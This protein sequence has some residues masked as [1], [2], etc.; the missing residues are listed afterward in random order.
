MIKNL[1]VR[2]T[3]TALALAGTLGLSLTACN[4][5]VVDFNK[6]F[7]VAIEPNGDSISVVPITKYADYQGSQVQFVTTDGLVVLSSTHQ[8]QLMKANSENALTSYTSH[9]V[10]DNDTINYYSTDVEYGDSF[11]KTIIDLQFVFKKAII[12]KGDS[13]IIM[14]IDTW[15]DY[16]EDDKIQIRLEDGTCILTD[17]ANI[18]LLDVRNA[19]E[20]A[21]LNYA[22]SL[23]GDKEKVKELKK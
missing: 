15:K 4:K 6:S 11:N 17:A 14:D 16:E 21:A 3:C 12:L 5:Q 23:V 19:P 18:K 10:D 9:L 13:A 7:N 2:K 20:D 8:L 22:T 1:N